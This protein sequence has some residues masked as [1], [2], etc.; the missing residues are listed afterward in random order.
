MDNGADALMRRA[1]RFG[2]A[3]AAEEGGHVDE[4]ARLAELIQLR[5]QER[6]EC[7]QEGVL[8]AK[9]RLEEAK[10]LVGICPGM[11][12][13]Y[14]YLWRKLR[15]NNIHSLEKDENGVPQWYL[16]IKD[17]ARSAAGN[18]QE[19]PS[20]VRPPDVLLRTTDYLLSHLLT[21][22]PFTAVNQAFIRDRARAIV[23][24]FTMQHVRNAPAI[25]AHERIVRMAA[26]SMHIFRDQRQPDGPF[27]HDGE[28]KQFVN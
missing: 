2:K 5:A 25:E 7:E 1:Q 8:S 27:D 9:T 24:D 18:E 10:D 22:H 12:S 3:P 16:T 14:Q 21:T 6:K 4:E 15:Y 26:I 13:E 28:R 11:I 17:Y 23:K 20:D 19:L